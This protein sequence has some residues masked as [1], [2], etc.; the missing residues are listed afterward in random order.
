MFLTKT[1]KIV[2]TN[3]V[4]I[5]LIFK[6]NKPLFEKKKGQAHASAVVQLWQVRDRFSGELMNVFHFSVNL[7]KCC[8]F[9]F[10]QREDCTYSPLRVADVNR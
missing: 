8:I 4:D 1:V 9:V 5:S 10:S 7:S 2:R 3:F 6:C